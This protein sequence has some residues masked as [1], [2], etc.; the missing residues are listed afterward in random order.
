MLIPY[1]PD[2]GNFIRQPY[3]RADPAAVFRRVA[4]G[5]IVEA[6]AGDADHPSHLSVIA[7]AFG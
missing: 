1:F 5:V 3:A 7:G 2:K 6:A 4:D